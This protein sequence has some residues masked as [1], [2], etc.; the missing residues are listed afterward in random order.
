M[1]WKTLDELPTIGQRVIVAAWEFGFSPDYFIARYWR[2]SLPGQPPK[3]YLDETYAVPIPCN[4]GDTVHY[5]MPIPEL[6][7]QDRDGKK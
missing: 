4:I 1:I 5:W 3:F 2:S 6:P 7:K